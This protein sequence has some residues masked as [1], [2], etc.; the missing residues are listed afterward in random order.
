[1]S[2][3]KTGSQL[4][5]EGLKYFDASVRHLEVENQSADVAA[6]LYAVLLYLEGMYCEVDALVNKPLHPKKKASPAKVNKPVAKA[7]VKKVVAKVV[8][9]VEVKKAAPK[10][11]AKK[12]V[13]PAANSGKSVAKKT[14]AVVAKPAKKVSKAKK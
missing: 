11:V 4:L 7:P 6:R 9:K 12:V 1:M 13:K 8:K 2:N 5:L 14:V 10:T 3:I